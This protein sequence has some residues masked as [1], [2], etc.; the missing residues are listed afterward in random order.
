[1]KGL[2]YLL[3]S[4]LIGLCLSP[5]G[6]LSA[7]YAEGGVPRSLSPSFAQEE[8][9]RSLRKQDTLYLK[10]PTAASLRALEQ[11]AATSGYRVLRFAVPLDVELSTSSHGTWRRASDGSAIWFL[12]LKSAGATSLGLNFSRYQMPTGAKLYV[13][14]ANGI[15]RGAF[16]EQNN[17][18]SRVLTMAP[19]RGEWVTLELNLPAGIS[20]E[21]LQLSLDK[22]Y[23][24]YRDIYA[25]SEG[26]AWSYNEGEPF[27]DFRGS[28]L[29]QLRCTPNISAYP[30]YTKQSRAVVLQVVEGNT[31]STGTLINTTANDGT[32]YVLTAAHNINRLYSSAVVSTTPN[33]PATVAKVRNICKTIVFFF[34]FESP[35]ADADIRG[36]EE[37][38][39]S[40]AELVAYNEEA[41]MA[42]LKITGL[43]RDPM[44]LEYIPAS[45]NVYFAGWNISA[46]PQPTYYGI[47]HPLASTK[48]LSIVA[49]QSLALEDYDLIDRYW[50]M[51][52]W[53]VRRWALGMTA[54]GSSGSPLF[55]GGGRVIGALSGGSSSCYDPTEDYYYALTATWS[56][57]TALTSLKPWL[58]PSGTGVQEVSGY[59]PHAALPVSR[60]STL[61][62]TTT[63]GLLTTYQAQ[64]QISGVGR[65]V[66]IGETTEPL[67]VFVQLGEQELLQT[68]TPSY[69]L[70]LTPLI[71]GAP[72]SAP[73]WSTTLSNYHFAYYK[74][75]TGR[76]TEGRRTTGID[77]IEVFVPSQSTASLPSGNYLLSLRTTSDARLD[78]P[79]LTRPYRT[80]SAQYASLMWHKS[81]GGAWSQEGAS[82]KQ[83]IWLDLL[84]RG[85]RHDQ[86]SITREGSQDVYTSYAY[87]QNLYIYSPRGSAELRVYD[88]TGRLHLESTV[89]EG[90][91]TLSMSDL[92]PQQIY[93]VQIKGELGTLAYKFRPN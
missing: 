27:Y 11:S 58:D 81:I 82:S 17:S 16:T 37:K 18:P 25:R 86:A 92:L 74:N 24:G 28:G 73:V 38:T 8:S 14:G 19:I 52:H 56:N 48:R 85:G 34:G 43:P 50:T 45:Y 46:S 5:G 70:E 59:D 53:Y 72:S 15:V 20:P 3:I 75:D 33:D 62:G 49:D 65:I 21:Q 30:E 84:V 83:S 68:E 31:L 1:M 90:E 55:D 54:S 80:T 32:A 78:Y 9:F 35:S 12:T 63:K 22:V 47:H 91:T 71:A 13:H 36:S 26:R 88:L 57:A 2:R 29:T 66:S 23:Y 93:I 41:D 40:G 39:L 89:S 76:F 7:Q 44:G 4:L 69:T 42:L 61:Y 51:K 60:L 77:A 67:G 6:R 10:P 64:E 87:R 79:I